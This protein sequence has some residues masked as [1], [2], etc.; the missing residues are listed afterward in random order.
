MEDN[1][2]NSLLKLEKFIVK[3]DLPD[4][5]PKLHRTANIYKWCDALEVLLEIENNI[6]FDEI[7]K[8]S[9]TFEIISITNEY[10]GY[11]FNTIYKY[12]V[13]ELFDYIIIVEVIYLTNTFIFIGV[14]DGLY[15]K[16][17]VE[18]GCFD[19]PIVYELD[20]NEYL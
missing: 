12:P 4:E 13:Y 3:M 11:N 14:K 6:D 17:Y 2:N 8:N 19:K 18:N 16:V 7:Y 5:L 15:Y 10:G 1:T 20:V 9:I